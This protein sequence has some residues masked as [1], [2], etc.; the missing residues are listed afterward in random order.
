MRIFSMEKKDKKQN[1][2]CNICWIF[3]PWKCAIQF[4]GSDVMKFVADINL[5]STLFWEDVAKEGGCLGK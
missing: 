5:I 1:E 3:F 2:K 4:P